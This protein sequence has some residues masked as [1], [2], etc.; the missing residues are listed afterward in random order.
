MRWFDIWLQD[1]NN[2]RNHIYDADDN[3]VVRNSKKGNS[4]VRKRKNDKDNDNETVPKKLNKRQVQVSPGS[5]CTLHLPQQLRWPSNGLWSEEIAGTSSHRANKSI[6]L[7]CFWTHQM[8]HDHLD[9]AN[10]SW[11]LCPNHWVS[12][13]SPYIFS[14]PLN[15]APEQNW[16]KKNKKK[17]T[18]AWNWVSCYR[19]WV[20]QIK[21]GLWMGWDIMEILCNIDFIFPLLGLPDLYGI[22]Q[23]IFV[24]WSSSFHCL[25]KWR[26]GWDT[27][28]YICEIQFKLLLLS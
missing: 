2:D 20:D 23:N 4:S 8:M 1:V 26:I 12:T 28:E 17:S 18:K 11:R 16:S 25:V 5:H 21:D 22:Q 9:N 13:I 19:V 3:A 24:R 6:N 15:K 10:K 7:V 27:I 14:T